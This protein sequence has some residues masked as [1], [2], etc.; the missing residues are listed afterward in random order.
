MQG[1]GGAFDVG[2][3]GRNTGEVIGVFGDI[4]ITANP[5]ISGYKTSV[6]V[7]TLVGMEEQLRELQ[8]RKSV[9]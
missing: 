7:P 1:P 9:V 3:L 8:D 4:N 5:G 6:N 2:A